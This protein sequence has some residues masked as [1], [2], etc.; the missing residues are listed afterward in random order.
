MRRF[1]RLAL[2]LAVVLA[3][4]AAQAAA[5]I[6]T[7]IHIADGTLTTTLSTVLYT[8]PAATKTM[9]L[10]MNFANTSTTTVRRV[11]VA[12]NGTVI[13]PAKSIN[14]NEAYLWQ[15]NFMLNTTMTITSGQDVGTDVAYFISGATIE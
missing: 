15:G 7:N 11:T 10:S 13:V 12:F 8:V 1:A 3:P 6:Y 4:F 9:V 14:P 2:T 5:P